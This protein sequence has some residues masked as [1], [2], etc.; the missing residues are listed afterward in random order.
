M[1]PGL[2]LLFSSVSPPV[3]LLCCVGVAGSACERERRLVDRGGAGGRG[4]GCGGG[5]A[6]AP[7]WLK[8]SISISSGPLSS[9]HQRAAGQ[10]SGVRLL[11]EEIRVRDAS[12]PSFC[13]PI[14]FFLFLVSH[15]SPKTPPNLKLPPIYPGYGSL[16]T[17]PEPA[18]DRPALAPPL[19]LSAPAS[20]SPASLVRRLP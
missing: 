16:A 19:P 9:K 1:R 5:G 14:F 6:M 20:G 17:K 3:F 18:D 7:P 13:L 12:G 10:Q 11:T 2:S 8:N 15:F 4:G